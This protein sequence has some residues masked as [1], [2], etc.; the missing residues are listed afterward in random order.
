M[1]C[2]HPLHGWLSRSPSSTG[3]RAITFRIKDGFSDRPM[4]V[5][6]GQ[7]IGCRLERSRQWALRCVHEAQFHEQSCFITLTYNDEHLPKNKSLVKDDFQR[8]MKR[9]RKY[10][11]PQDVRYFHCG[12]YGETILRPH[13]HAILFGVDFDDKVLFKVVN[14]VRVFTSQKLEKIWGKG[15]VTIGDVTFE[16]A[17]YVARYVLKKITGDKAAEHYGGRLPEYVTMSLKPGIGSAWFERYWYEVYPNDYVV[18]RGMKCK[19]PRFYDKKF[20]DEM[21]FTMET[22]KR[23]RSAMAAMHDNSP[24]RLNAKEFIKMQAISNLPRNAI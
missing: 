3:G 7:C 19:P 2:Y 10:F 12:E 21:P 18:A 11:A 15:F 4:T 22:I 16:S 23:A 24:E 5:P 8:F 20:A 14:G 1:T 13:Y 17:A 6:C 9:L